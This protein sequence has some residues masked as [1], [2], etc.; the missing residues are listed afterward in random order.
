MMNSLK[1]CLI[2]YLLL[3]GTFIFATDYQGFS[4]Y[5]R[6]AILLN[7]EWKYM[8][9][10]YE[11]GYYNYRLE[12]FDQLDQTY[13]M[14]FYGDQKIKNPGDL[15]EYDFDKSPSLMVPG[16]WNTQDPRLYYYEGTVWYRKKFIGPELESGERIYLYFS[17]VNYRADVYLNSKKLG[18]HIGGF[19]PFWYDV[20]DLMKTD[21]N[22]LV[23]RVDN[24]RCSSCVP[25]LN[26]DWWNY[27]GIT[28]EVKLI[29]LP[30]THIKDFEIHLESAQ[31]KKI[32]GKI[33][34]DNAP[35]G[36][37]VTV[38]VPELKISVTAKT[39]SKGI[40]EFEF[41]PGKLELW[42][43]ENPK[44]Y[45]V[46]LSTQA[47]QLSDTIAFRTIRTEGKQILLND[48]PV[49]LRGISVHEEY[50]AEGDGR[51]N[52]DWKAAQLLKWAKELGCNFVRLAHYP[53][54]EDMVR[55]AEKMGIMVWSEVPV[56][57]TIDWTNDET[58][59]NAKNQIQD[60]ILRDRNRGNIIIWS[61]ANETPVIE[62]RTVFLRKLI[63]RVR[64]LDQTRLISAAL[65]KHYLNDSVA[66][67]QDPLAEYLDVV[68]FNE[69]VGW[70]DGL[71][72]KCSRISWLIEYNK[73]VFVS[74]F[75]G[76]AKFGYHGPETTRWT[77]EFQ[78]N[79][80]FRSLNMLDQ[81][82][83]LCG[84]SPWILCDFRSPRRA[85]PE[86]QDGFNRKGVLSEKGEKKQ[87]FYVLQK[88]YHSK[89]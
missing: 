26:T 46:L 77:E 47:D 50:S 70:Y 23:V 9:D 51:V 79:L 2:V 58:L 55:I 61:I 33:W 22:S 3:E 57:W 44:R 48:K 75:G 30:G 6:A 17:A 43:P 59:N 32:A 42:S 67:V 52:A 88:Y 24:K 1:Y 87:A 11:N 71:P 78:A 35:E 60:N 8:V 73:P 18:T 41:T 74:E 62:D 66:V 85:L 72:E 4:A 34:V 37:P 53:H 13:S 28:R 12:P 16:D 25:T 7:G 54:N 20:T 82:D 81:I 84:I 76:G 80:Y 27:G 21:N 5:T 63:N 38:S 40:A 45:S 15:I 64:E 69:Y 49:F 65:E 10:P 56:Y 89:K 36:E 14:G 68:A 86:I 83:G 19:T 29:R 39:N 31:S